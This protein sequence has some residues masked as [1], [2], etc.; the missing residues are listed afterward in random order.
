MSLRVLAAGGVEREGERAWAV[1]GLWC[2]IPSADEGVGVVGRRL[3]AV[4]VG[5]GLPVVAVVAVGAGW[6]LR[7]CRAGVAL[8]SGGS[9]WSG[10]SVGA[11]GPR[12]AGGTGRAG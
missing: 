10:R 8:R 5:A 3:E 7:A 6:P 2:A 1:A 9:W 11:S 4:A 12:G